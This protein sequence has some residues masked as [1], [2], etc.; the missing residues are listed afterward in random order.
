MAF[1]YTINNLRT[2]L[3]NSL[4]GTTLN[5]VSGV[6]NIIQRAGSE[7]LLELDPMETKR[8]VSFT[9][10][11]F[12]QV[13]DYALPVDLKG[14]KI[15]DIRPQA[16]RT[17]RDLY[18]NGYNQAFDIS[19]SYVYQPNFTV[20]LNTGIKTI[21]I[22]NNLLISGLMLNA[23]DSITGN[24][25]WVASGGAT[26]LTQN[27]LQFTD[28][29]S[30]SISFNTLAGQTT[31][32]LTNSTMQAQDMTNGYLQAHQFLYSFMNPASKFSQIE[33]RF[34]SSASNYFR[35]T[36]TTTQSGTAFQ[37]GWNLMQGNWATATVVGTPVVTAI[38]Y[39]QVIWTYDS[40][41]ITDV[42]LNQIWSRLGELSEIEYYSKYLYQDAST[43]AFL[44]TITDNSN[45][46]NLDT[47]TRNLLYLL[48]LSYAVQQI[49]GL[50]A[51][52]FD[53][54]YFQQKYNTALALYKAQYKSEWQKPKSSYYLFPNASYL[55]KVS[56]RNSW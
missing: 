35:E 11:I 30:S 29:I 40:T 16:N 37:N 43:G 28:G 21:R 33:L 31:A 14:T 41:V 42:C 54:Q 34:G 5:K 47:E 25:L 51:M 24:G 55:R 26:N 44:E 4:H 17:Y 27:N 9:S 3:E 53:D 45:I 10:P 13:Y 36:F 19:K 23:A 52:F 22:D 7:L 8:I 12:Q 18:L 49:Q 15:I 46:I 48:T 2:D 39:I 32:I 38:N 20:Q 1:T 6:N 56:K 50:D